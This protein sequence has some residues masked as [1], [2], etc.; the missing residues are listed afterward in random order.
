MLETIISIFLVIQWKCSE[1]QHA[2][3][4]PTIRNFRNFLHEYVAWSLFYLFRHLYHSV[5]D[6]AGKM[7]YQ[8]TSPNPSNHP[9]RMHTH[10][11]LTRLIEHC[12]A[13]IICIMLGRDTHAH[14]S[15]TCAV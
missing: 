2:R 15:D 6:I 5:G 12:T 9:A 7:H 8:S 11:E 1:V 13:S 14:V 3:S 4:R 10:L